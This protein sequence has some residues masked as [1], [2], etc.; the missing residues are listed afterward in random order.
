MELEAPEYQDLE[1]ADAEYRSLSVLAIAA[2]V[3]GL[4]SP[5][6]FAHPLWWGL[7]IAGIGLAIGAI[8]RIDRSDG[9]LGGRKAAIIGLVLSLIC[10]LGAIS[11]AASRRVWLEHRANQVAD[12]FLELLRDGK[13]YEA[14]QLWTRPQYRF[15]AGS[16][17]EKL[18]ADSP[19]AEKDY[20]DFVKREI[21]SDLLALGNRAQVERLQTRVTVSKPDLDYLIVNYHIS[22][23]TRSGNIDKEIGLV[24]ERV[25][26]DDAT[27]RWRV[28]GDDLAA[29]LEN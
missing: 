25:V 3:I 14:H 15:P 13:T 10:G 27:D 18:Y 4:L 16:D 7:P 28:Y 29:N 22:G 1:L 26:E 5:L 20:K 11:K 21:I 23:P 24:I 12:R 8:F 17:F 19:G 9:A 2:L 6:A